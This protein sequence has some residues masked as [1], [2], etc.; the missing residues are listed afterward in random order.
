VSLHF[1]R[2]TL[3]RHGLRLHRKLGQNFLIEDAMAEKLALRSGVEAGD[4][5]IEVGTGLGV[6]TRAL[7]KRAERVVTIEIDS[8]LVAALRGDEL[9]PENVEL[10]HADA[11]E[12]DLRGLARDFGKRPVRVVANLPY[13][14]AS[15]L[16]RKL[17]DLQHALRD[18]S[19]MLQRELAD[20]LV[21]ETGTRDYGSLTVLHRLVVD[22]SRE[23]ELKPRCFFP[24]PKVDS[25]FVRLFPREDSPLEPGELPEVERV[26]RALFNH[27]RKTI[28][29]G[30]RGAGLAASGDSDALV[31]ALEAVQVDPRQRAEKLEPEVLLALSRRLRG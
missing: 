6:L 29:N 13:S 5:V 2:D 1:V 23:I 24:A 14:V 28:L 30:L 22:V 10:V 17:L 31:A 18:W 12:I 27:R 21:A 20:R 8:G 15:P 19:V 7:A 25:S 9:L 3:D 4:G 11:L 26:V 16:L